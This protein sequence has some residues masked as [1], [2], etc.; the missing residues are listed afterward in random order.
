VATI[1]LFTA[2]ISIN[3]AVINSL[4]F[5]ALDGGQLVFVLTEAL[6]GRRVNQRFQENVTAVAVLFLLLVS[7]STFVGDLKSVFGR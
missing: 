1:V 7:L 2:A 6:T 4:P 3:L 5:P